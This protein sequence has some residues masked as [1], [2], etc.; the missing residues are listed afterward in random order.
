MYRER[1]FSMDR[2]CGRFAAHVNAIEEFIN[3]YDHCM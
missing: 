3:I 2:N 1:L